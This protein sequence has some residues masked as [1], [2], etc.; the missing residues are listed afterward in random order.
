M[1]SPRND[2]EFSSVRREHFK[3]G[4]PRFPS[5]AWSLSRT[6]SLPDEV[7][8]ACRK[9]STNTSIMD[10]H[11]H[12]P[13]LFRSMRIQTGVSLGLCLY[14]E[15]FRFSTKSSCHSFPASGRPYASPRR[16]QY[17]S[18]G[19]ASRRSLVSASSCHNQDI[20]LHWSRPTHI[21]GDRIHRFPRTSI[22]ELS[23]KR[24]RLP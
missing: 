4:R 13:A 19:T 12:L 7:L 23:Q 9:S 11:R 8:Q 15:L 5:S 14:P 22:Q 17:H 16:T 1:L 3:G 24:T 21:Q 10:K 20:Q 2:T 6:E 18:L